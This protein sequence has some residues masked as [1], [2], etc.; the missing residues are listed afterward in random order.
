MDVQNPIGYTFFYY[1]AALYKPHGIDIC[2]CEDYTQEYHVGWL[3][4]KCFI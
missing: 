1:K 4:R 3:G 2:V